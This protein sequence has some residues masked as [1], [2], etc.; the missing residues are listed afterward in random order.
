MANIRIDA[1]PLTQITVIEVEPD[2]SEDALG[3]LRERARFM[4]SQP[5]FISVSLHRSLDRRRIVN[6]V[7]WQSRDLLQ[8]AHESPE[9][10]KAWQR[11]DELTDAIEPSL[12]EVEQVFDA[13]TT[14]VRPADVQPTP[15]PG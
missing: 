1:Q 8:A 14:E 4:S 11:F 2:R 9:F 12:Y 5:G 3:I 15:R 6:Y 13:E 10:R 7:Q